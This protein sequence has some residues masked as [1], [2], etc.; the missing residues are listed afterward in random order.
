ML[1]SNVLAQLT[2]LKT[3]IQSSKDY[4]EGTV[5]AT[6]GRFGFVRTDDGRDAFLSP[7]KMDRLLPGDRVKIEVIDKGKGKIEAHLE[8][9]L[10]SELSKFVGQY[11]VKGAGHFVVPSGVKFCRWIFIPPAQ[12][13]GAKDGDFVIAKISRHP[14]RDGKA[15]A[16]IVYKIGQPDEPY[17][18]HK[19]TKAKYDL[20]YRT[21]SAHQKQVSA[22]QALF[23]EGDFGERKDLSHLDFLTIDSVHTL[24]MDDALAIEKLDDTDSYR[25]YAAI[26]AP[27]SFI[28]PGS[29]LAKQAQSSAQTVYLLG[30]AV[31][32]FPANVGNHCFS[33][34][35]GE[36][37][38]A[39]VCEMLVAS[40][41]TISEFSFYPA[42]VC[43]RHKLNYEQVAS[44]L[45]DEAKTDAVP[46]DIA[47]SLKLL[48]EASSIRRTLRD[49]EQVLYTDHFDYDYQLDENGKIESISRRERSSSQQLVEEAMVA[50][51]LCA[52]SFLAK[53]NSG[54]H[55]VHSGFRE[56]RIGEVRALLKEE[57]IEH[58]DI[59]T[60][61]EHVHLVKT[62][63]NEAD[64]KAL[65]P[66]LRRMMVSGELSTHAA[67]HLGMG[68]S[69]YATVTSPIRRFA[70]IFNHWCILAILAGK[71]V[72]SL[73]EA[74]QE[75]LNESIRNGRQADRELQQWLITQFTEK[76]I[77]TTARGKIRIVTQQGFGVKTF[78]TGIEGFVLFG[79]K[80]KKTFDAKRMTLTIGEQIYRIDDE[81][82]VNIV[83]VDHDKRRIAFELVAKQE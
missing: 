32:M 42:S 7:E 36:T 12:R 28:E 27:G 3:D 38:P 8:K 59:N 16:N 48:F 52:A 51:N 53:H 50:T 65:L 43:S 49:A 64:K 17:I 20:N 55:I 23:S 80:V 30:G 33:L 78:D 11:R 63:S 72:P 60:L 35:E 57:K 24:D 10:S 4:A 70:D 68:V 58:G 25:L 31:P 6:S 37:R 22:I 5:A 39:L 54:I 2:Q 18:E 71:S 62:L 46:D 79:K 29:V 1:D 34:I 26:A 82:D 69:G 40:N 75:T 61:E 13:K 76:L 44:F 41:G 21:D 74:E 73:S 83:S 77:G 81:I 19:Y 9:F 15:Q 45:D 47:N 67:P 66:A 56:D 14:Y